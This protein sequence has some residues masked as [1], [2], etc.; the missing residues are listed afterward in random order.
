MKTT[1]EIL[2]CDFINELYGEKVLLTE[3]IGK[4]HVNVRLYKGEVEELEYKSRLTTSYA[5]LEALDDRMSELKKIRQI[6]NNEELRI[7]YNFIRIAKQV[8]K[9][10]TYG[11]IYGLAQNSLREIKSM[12]KELR[13]NKIE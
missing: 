2:K 10:E 7:Q 11:K 9:S 3:E 13:N 1:E 12:F 4:L 5:I 8:L 6:E